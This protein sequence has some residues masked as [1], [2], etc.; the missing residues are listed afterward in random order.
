[1]RELRLDRLTSASSRPENVND[2]PTQVILARL[3]D[4]TQFGILGFTPL[5]I[6]AEVNA[7]L[8]NIGARRLSTVM[9]RL[10]D[11]V[12]DPADEILLDSLPISIY[13]GG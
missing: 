6:A 5:K 7:A 4:N 2:T 13:G 11:E 8:E 12:P 9:E 3:L 1:M 10:L